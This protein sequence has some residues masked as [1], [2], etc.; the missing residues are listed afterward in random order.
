MSDFC[1]QCSISIFG[2]DMRDLADMTTTVTL[3][4]C[5]GCGMI[6]VDK[7]GKCVDDGCPIHGKKLRTTVK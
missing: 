6:Q 2:D 3:V 5:E 1:R 4:L 7:D